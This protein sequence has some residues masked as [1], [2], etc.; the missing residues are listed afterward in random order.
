MHIFRGM[1]GGN[2]KCLKIE[3]ADV[4]VSVL[5]DKDVRLSRIMQRDGITQ[6]E[7]ERRMRAQQNDAFYAERSDYVLDNTDHVPERAVYDMLAAM[8]CGPDGD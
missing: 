7:A 4:V 5:A 3:V 8:G 2:Y 6:E 1:K